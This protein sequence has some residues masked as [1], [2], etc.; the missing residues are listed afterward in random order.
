MLYLTTQLGESLSNRELVMLEL[1][2]AG[3]NTTEIAAMM[4][5]DESLTE[6]YKRT[7]LK[8]MNVPGIAELVAR[9]L[10]NGLI[11]RAA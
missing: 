3:M 10:R 1:Y 7:L 4:D 6:V 9:A 2:A 8:K 5:L 11:Q